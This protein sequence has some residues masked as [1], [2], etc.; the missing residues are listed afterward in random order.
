MVFRLG[1]L[2]FRVKELKEEILGDHSKSVSLYE[3]SPNRM[4]SDEH[5]NVFP[6]HTSTCR[7]C[8]GTH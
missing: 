2:R 8:F 6:D 3:N 5:F 1:I 7:I 4:E